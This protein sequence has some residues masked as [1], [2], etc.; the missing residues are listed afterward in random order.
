L[1]LLT[2]FIVVGSLSVGVVFVIVCIEV[3]KG[4]REKN[5]ISAVIPVFGDCPPQKVAAQMV[6]F[7]SMGAFLMHIFT[8]KAPRFKD[9]RNLKEYMTYIRNPSVI[10]FIQS[11]EGGVEYE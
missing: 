7:V 9:R 8:N 10:A 2:L 11:L 4:A 5:A 1:N 6:T 3:F